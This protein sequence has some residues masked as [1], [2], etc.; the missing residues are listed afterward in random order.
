MIEAARSQVWRSVQAVGGLQSPA[1][2]CLWN[3]VGWEKTLKEWAI[4]G[5]WRGQRIMQETASG[6]LVATLGMLDQHI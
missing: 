4:E 2:S 5:A 1:G 3:V 6:I